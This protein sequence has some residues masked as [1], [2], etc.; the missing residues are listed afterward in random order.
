MIHLLGVITAGVG[1]NM[2]G[3]ENTVSREDMLTL[4]FRMVKAE[5]ELAKECVEMG[6]VY[7]ED[8][9]FLKPLLDHFYDI[10]LPAM[11][12]GYKYIPMASIWGSVPS[13]HDQ[14]LDFFENACIHV[15]T[16]H[17]LLQQFVTVVLLSI[18][19]IGK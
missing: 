3:A 15:L 13:N 4:I 12:M 8:H 17:Q 1:D 9:P 11:K 5:K 7:M 18:Q 6:L 14:M 2:F 19:K 10:I 16:T